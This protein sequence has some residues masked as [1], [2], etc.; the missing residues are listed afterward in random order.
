MD[1]KKVLTLTH[2]FLVIIGIIFLAS[3]IFTFVDPHTMG[4]ALGIAPMNPS[5]E[6]EIR[7]TYGGLVVGSGLLVLS[8]LFHR[9]MTVAALAGTFFGAGGLVST[10]IVIQAM[11]GFTIN[12]GI[13]AAFELTMVAIAF[14]L[15][16]AA[17]KRALV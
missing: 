10:R 17:M 15:L 9:L 6:T 14:L 13:V 16:R 12:Q 3:G 8:G 4:E 7:A 1:D 5:G 2:I 11:D